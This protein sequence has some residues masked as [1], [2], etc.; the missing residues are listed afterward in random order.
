MHFSPPRFLVS[1]PAY[2]AATG[3]S[4]SVN[5]VCQVISYNNSTS[6]SYARHVS[7]VLMVCPAIFP[8]STILLLRNKATPSRIFVVQLLII[9]S[10][11]EMRQQHF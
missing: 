3:H 4:S 10:V 5:L 2:T 6:G 9:V 7:G 1:L 11:G 8:M